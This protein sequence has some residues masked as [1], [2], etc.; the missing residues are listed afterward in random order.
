MEINK[1]RTFCKNNICRSCL[2]TKFE[3]KTLIVRPHK[4]NGIGNRLSGIRGAYTLAKKT[5]RQFIID[6][7]YEETESQFFN[8]HHHKVF[9]PSKYTSFN[10]GSCPLVL[11]ETF[12]SMSLKIINMAHTNEKV[13]ILEQLYNDLGYIENAYEIYNTLLKP[14]NEF[15][16]QLKAYITNLKL[17]LKKGWIGVQLRRND[18]KHGKLTKN[19]VKSLQKTELCLANMNKKNNQVFLTTNS[20]DISSYF[21]IYNFVQNEDISYRKHSSKKNGYKKALLEFATLASSN[22]I[23]GTAGSTFA[24]E[25]SFFGG[26]RV[27]MRKQNTYILKNLHESG[28]CTF[29]A[30]YGKNLFL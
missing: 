16:Q 27:T 28:N 18:H 21:K 30:P 14:T 29:I 10:S 13:I 23:L 24:R 5:N 1:W 15:K 3:N 12:P 4:N 2:N 26:I 19:E 11:R 6:W 17:D 20:I 9:Q 25:A 22:R 7:P 8:I